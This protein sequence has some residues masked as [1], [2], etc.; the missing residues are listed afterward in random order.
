MAYYNQYN[1][2]SV[3]YPSRS[4]PSA[5]VSSSGCGVCC[6]SM[7][8]EGLTGQT[9]TP[10]Q[11]APF[12]ISAGARVDGGTDMHRLGAAAARRWDLTMTTTS[13][14]DELLAA[15]RRGG[16]VIANV[17]GDHGSYKGLF[18]NGGH[19]IVVS[20][21]Q[22]GKLVVYDPG[23]YDGKF[24]TTARHGKVTVNADKSISVMPSY[25]DIDCSNR[26]PRY[27]IYNK[28]NEMTQAEFDAMLKE[29]DLN[30][31][32]NRLSDLPAWAEPTIRKLCNY[33]YLLGSGAPRDEQ[34][35]PTDLNL[36]LDMVRLL[37]ITERAGL[38]DAKI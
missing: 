37:T 34:G 25:L 5:T 26:S 13:D 11:M 31:R 3:P 38:Y 7:V 24:S 2:K 22:N 20:A 12:A 18:S 14:V 33:G 4:K 9:V 16:V 28:E 15:I 6:M 17:G 23:Y 10:A 1:Y 21:Y 8:V 30:K 19:Y 29:S 27:Y 35:Y 32:Y 36:T